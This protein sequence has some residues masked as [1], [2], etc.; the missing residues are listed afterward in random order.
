MEK[1]ITIRF[2]EPLWRR[3]RILQEQKEIKSIQEAVISALK[4][5]YPKSERESNDKQS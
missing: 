2:P 5:K 3:L 1:R 4:F